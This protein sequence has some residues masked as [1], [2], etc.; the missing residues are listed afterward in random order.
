MSE[1]V[2][3][4]PAGGPA[5]GGVGAHRPERS[6]RHRARQ[7]LRATIAATVVAS[8]L[9]GVA[10][11][12]LVD[13]RQRVID[14]IDPAV[15]EVQR[16][17]AALVDQET[18]LRA[19]ALSGDRSYLEP[20]QSGRQEEV[21]SRDRLEDLLPGEEAD[22]RAATLDAAIDRWQETYAEPTI[23]AIDA[24]AV[25]G[26][27]SDGT[28]AGASPG[29]ATGRNRF[30]AIRQAGE[31]LEDHLLGERD[32]AAADLTRATVR[33][34]IALVLAEL[35]LLAVAIW[36]WRLLRRSVQRPLDA[37]RSDAVAV[38][39]GELDRPVTPVGPRELH[40][41]GVAMESMRERILAELAEATSSAEELR[42]Q[43]LELT[44]SNAELEQFAYVA[45]HDLQEP[46]RKVAAFC[47][48]LQSRYGGQLDERADQ[49][50][51]F[52]V[53][54]AKRMQALINDLLAFSRVGRITRDFA[55]VELDDA[56]RAAEANLADVIEESGARIHA[57]PLPAVHGEHAL[58]VAVFQNLIG[59]AVKFRRPD[60]APVIEIGHRC[61]D[62]VHHLTV[63]DNGIGIDPEYAERVFIIFQRL[64]AK[65]EY[66]GTGIGLALCRKIVEYHGGHIAVRA[67][68][69][70]GT[71]IELSL[72]V[73]AGSEPAADGGAAQGDAADGGAADGEEH[74][75]Q[76][77]ADGYRTERLQ[78]TTS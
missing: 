2:P 67:T 73:P 45:S 72:P 25:A 42:R 5:G 19:Y 30:D 47:Q 15:L 75:D 77:R 61:E 39:A 12:G 51:G 13:A 78:G 4:A 34:V 20:Y 46:L 33:L 50:I 44:R 55:T 8:L 35:L 74:T 40:D 14:R 17:R 28:A 18:G 36:A 64:H 60:V 38:A 57:E 6:L 62:G 68:G 10:L 16:L 56:L 53:D 58:L 63:A 70:P 66:P 9:G 23:A 7:V 65:E 3:S 11:V 48:L 24:G 41:L 27:G 29:L 59:N 71:V 31:E 21:A 32:R 26:T 1:D 69:G 43:Q 49:Y 52:A 22:E 54:G 76:Y 37:L